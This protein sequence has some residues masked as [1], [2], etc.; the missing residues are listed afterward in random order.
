MLKSNF[1]KNLIYKNYSFFFTTFMVCYFISLSYLIINLN[2]FNKNFLNNLVWNS[3]DFPSIENIPS[4]TG[5]GNH[6]FGDYLHLLTAGSNPI[7]STLYWPY[8]PFADL[9]SKP[10]LLF[11]FI[12]SYLIYIIFFLTFCF[13]N[14]VPLIKI[15]EKKDLILFVIFFV[16]CNLGSLY[17]IDRGNIQVIVTAF[18][19]IA[20]YFLI[21]YNSSKL[22]SIFIALSAAIK[23]WPILF[24]IILLKRKAF[25]EFCTGILFF[26]FAIASSLILMGL[27]LNDFVLYFT[28]LIHQILEFN[29]YS[30]M[31]WHAGAKNSSILVI[32]QI[33]KQENI[34]F[35]SLNFLTI[36]YTYFQ[37]IV[38]TIFLFLYFKSKNQIII[39]ELL[40]ISCL[41]LILPPAQYGYVTSLI[42]ILVPL[43]IYKSSDFSISKQ[44]N[45]WIIKKV[46]NL[47]LDKL[48]FLILGVILV[49]WTIRI[50]DLTGDVR[51]PMDLNSIFNPIGILLILFICFYILNSKFFNL[52]SNLNPQL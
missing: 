34:L 28:N 50:K 41:L 49:P 5:F 36:N 47:H 10:F 7:G 29:S 1:D 2:Y 22:F 42:A 38:F 40:L 44:F 12:T 9:L 46:F 13:I 43:L 15:L 48:I 39:I 11:P 31:F 17:L 27:K 16:I 32:F 3:D 23:L 8:L 26:T 6:F 4:V 35:E 30:G 14:V 51:Y 24:L 25:K 20:F 19:A 45:F 33:L 18:I 21:F 52:H 37:I